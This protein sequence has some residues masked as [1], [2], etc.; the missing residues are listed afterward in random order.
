LLQVGP[1][2]FDEL[3]RKMPDVVVDFSS[4]APVHFFAKALI[5]CD[6]FQGLHDGSMRMTP[7]RELVFTSK[8]RLQPVYVRT[9]LGDYKLS[10][11][12]AHVMSVRMRR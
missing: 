5:F 6:G 10:A 1:A 12:N 11:W 8:V 3:L 9:L 7:G 2:A 4:A